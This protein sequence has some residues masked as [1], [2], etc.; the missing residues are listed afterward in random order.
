MGDHILR[1]L[2]YKVCL[3]Q[4]NDRLNHKGAKVKL[5]NI[6]AVEMRFYCLFFIFRTLFYFSVLCSENK[7]VE[8]RTIKKRVLQSTLC[9][10]EVVLQHLNQQVSSGSPQRLSVGLASWFWSQEDLDF[11]VH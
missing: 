3:A 8:V 5:P 7:K 10:N 4:V 9:W 6:R 11:I 2:D 1:I